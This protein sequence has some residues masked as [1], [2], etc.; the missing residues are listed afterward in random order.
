[1]SKSYYNSQP[2]LGYRTYVTT[3][4][5]SAALDVYGPY[6]IYSR[7]VHRSWGDKQA[8]FA[9]YR[10]EANVKKGKSYDNYQPSLLSLQP[11]CQHIH[12]P[13]INKKAALKQALFLTDRP[14]PVH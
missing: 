9:L 1:M 2:S 13:N 14:A 12:T 10:A 5:G 6:T 11:V 4:T 3:I 8:V 7:S